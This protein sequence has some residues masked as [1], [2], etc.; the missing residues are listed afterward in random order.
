M[1]PPEPAVSA[2]HALAL[3]LST[4]SLALLGVDYYSL[5]WGMIGAYVALFQGQ[6]TMGR[7]QSVI[8]VA[9]STLVGAAVGTGVLSFFS[10][11]SRAL[12]NLCSLV[13]GFGAQKVVTALLNAGLSRIAKIGGES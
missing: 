7:V 13:A 10:S 1:P 3:A 12:L 4:V 9:L 6:R 11:E 5:V 2:A 8:F